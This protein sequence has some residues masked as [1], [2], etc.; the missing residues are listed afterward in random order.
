MGRVARAAKLIVINAVVLATLFVVADF[1]LGYAFN[2]PVVYLCRDPRLHHV[3]CPHAARIYQMDEVDGGRTIT[4]FWNVQG[5]RA[6]AP[7][8]S[9]P[10][11][12]REFDVVLVGDSFMEQRQVAFE[13]RVSTLMESR[14]G[15]KTLQAGT[16][17]WSV[18]NYRNWLLQHEFKTGAK[19]GVFIMAND[20]YAFGYGMSNVGYHRGATVVNGE[21]TWPDSVETTKTMLTRFLTN[22][23]FLF[24]LRFDR[25]QAQSA[26]IADNSYDVMAFDVADIADCNR[27]GG[28][29]ES[30]VTPYAKS[31]AV[32]AFHRWCWPAEMEENL[33]TVVSDIRAIQSHLA[34][35]GAELHIYFV[36][37]GWVMPKEA[38]AAKAH[39]TYKIDADAVI[40]SAGVVRALRDALSLPVVSLEDELIAAKRGRHERDVLYYYPM[41]AHW[42]R[43]GSSVVADIVVQ[44]LGLSPSGS[45]AGHR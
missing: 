14:T 18:I 45:I 8:K 42:N 35:H 15:A 27:L 39:P 24:Q 26:Q 17:S 5:L 22:N 37:N 34:K 11:D 28:I 21:P 2:K 31:V 1:S 32:Q 38:T 33:Q 40:T 23:S 10:L 30:K 44:S 25:A 12:T 7:D 20:L 4:S 16:G 43:V 9:M 36:P 13:D 41:D 6:V 19:V 29:L 3:H